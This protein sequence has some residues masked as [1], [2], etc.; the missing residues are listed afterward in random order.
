MSK[1]NIHSGIKQNDK[2]NDNH[3]MPMDQLQQEEH[4][5]GI[6]Y[7]GSQRSTDGNN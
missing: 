5:I 6:E 2:M 3:E 4:Y 1:N 7:C